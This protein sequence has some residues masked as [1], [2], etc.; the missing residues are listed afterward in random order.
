MNLFHK[1]TQKWCE[2]NPAYKSCCHPGL[3]YAC[4][5]GTP[6]LAPY[7]GKVTKV[8]LMNPT[9][10][11]AIHFLFTLD[12][13]DYGMRCMHLSKL[14][15]VGNYKAGEIIGYTGNTGMSTGP[16]LHIDIWKD[17]YIRP[18]NITTLQGIKDNQIDPS[19]I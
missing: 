10:G 2:P 14:P 13:K 5:V 17:G 12:G 7:D 11:N 6:I 16:H 19:T 9:M 1:V 8:H 15:T 18:E 3:D 4:P